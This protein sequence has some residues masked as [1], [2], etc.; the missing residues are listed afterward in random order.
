MAIAITITT[1]PARAGAQVDGNIAVANL[2]AVTVTL[3]SAP[4]LEI[5][6]A[7]PVIRQ[8]AIP[9]PA[10]I[11]AGAIVNLPFA[12]VCQAPVAAGPPSQNTGANHASPYGRDIL[13]LQATVSGTDSNGAVSDTAQCNVAVAALLG[14]NPST[15]GA[16][17]FNAP[18]NAVNTLFI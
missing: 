8:P 2:G 14:P 4:L 12:F 7:V 15:G 9:S 10:T 13:T 17:Q 16:L 6:G 11:A 5:N 18:S 1:K 3:T